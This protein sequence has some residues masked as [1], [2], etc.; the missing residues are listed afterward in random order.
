M[1]N[2]WPP[3][4]IRL[5][6]A[7]SSLVLV[8]WGLGQITL[9]LL[10]GVTLYLAWTLHQ[11]HRLLQWLSNPMP[12]A[13]PPES[14]GL[15]GDLFD[16]LYRQQKRHEQSRQHL[17]E[18]VDR[19]QQSTNALAY[20]VIMTDIRGE[21]EWWNDA[22]SQLLG[23]KFPSDRGQR[24]GNLV[25]QPEFQRYFER[26]QYRTPIQLMSPA[27][28]NLFLSVNISLFGEGDRLLLV[29]DITQLRRLE[30]MRKDFVSNVSH[31]LRTPLTVITGYLETLHDHKDQLP[32]AWHRAFQS[33]REQSSR[34]NHLIEDLLLLSKFE[35]SDAQ[36]RQ[37]RVSI[38]VL[39]A[40]LRQD[41]EAL[42][43]EKKHQIHF[44]LEAGDLL[45]SEQQL[46][47]AFSNLVVNAIK[48]TPA[49]GEIHVHWGKVRT[50]GEFVVS[51]NGKGFDPIHIPRLT[52]RFYRVDAGRDASEGGTGLGLAIV[53]HVLINHDA[54]LKIQSQ[55]GL[56]STF[57]CH[58][59]E[60][61]MLESAVNKHLITADK[62]Y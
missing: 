38:K 45:G 44:K 49:G 48:Y 22:A 19:I 54:E 11:L 29:Q 57:S 12:D 14:S 61:R 62:D 3:T 37:Q 51:D 16:A 26:N 24:I 59:P 42:N 41:A 1:K 50:G 6:I 10:I 33:M 35:T 39:M 60:S 7:G 2:P 30:Q 46:R 13:A 23:L 17:Q 43:S 56:G 32:R 5:L 53:K 28:P 31:E 15:W 34:M 47:S 55:P 20:G 58:F 18:Y 52:E 9:T 4:L 40:G 21:L 27:N 25:R 8:G 36:N